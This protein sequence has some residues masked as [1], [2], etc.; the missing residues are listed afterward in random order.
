M[1][2]ITTAQILKN[3]ESGIISHFHFHIEYLL[4]KLPLISDQVSE[5]PPNMLQLEVTS[6]Y[7]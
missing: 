4:T 2:T 5:A 1:L 6:M 3:P 7:F